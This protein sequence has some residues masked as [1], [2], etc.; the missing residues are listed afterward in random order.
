MISFDPDRWLNATPEMK[1]RMMVFGGHVRQCIG[2]N[3][4]KLQFFHSVF[5]FIRECGHTKLA[6]VTNDESMTM[7]DYFTIKPVAEKC[8]IVPM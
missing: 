4:A 7:V 8:M 5:K 6:P 2:Q 3:I 1:E